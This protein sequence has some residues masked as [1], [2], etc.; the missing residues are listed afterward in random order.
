MLLVHLPEI[1]K[2]KCKST[3]KQ[4]KNLTKGKITSNKNR[5]CKRYKNETEEVKA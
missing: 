5:E 1:V 4:K 3:E 2:A